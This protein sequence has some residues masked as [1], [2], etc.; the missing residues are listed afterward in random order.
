MVPTPDSA[1]QAPDTTELRFS[2]LASLSVVPFKTIEPSFPL[3]P[4]SSRFDPVN[5]P[6]IFIEWR[7]AELVKLAMPERW[8]ASPL[9]L[10]VSCTGMRSADRTMP[11]YGPTGTAVRVPLQVPV[12]PLAAAQAP[13]AD[14]T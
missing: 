1:W 9:R 11:E 6:V 4:R 3:S 7:H 10:R 5:V 13:V 2:V 14:M 12:S 8:P